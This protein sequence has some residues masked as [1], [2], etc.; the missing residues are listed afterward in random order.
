MTNRLRIRRN[1]LRFFGRTIFFLSWLD[2]MGTILLAKARF[3]S[4][5][6]CFETKLK[7]CTMASIIQTVLHFVKL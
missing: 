7:P 5:K 6:I 1:A 3:S 2:K 4:K